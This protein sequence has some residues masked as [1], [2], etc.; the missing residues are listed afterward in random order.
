MSDLPFLFEAEPI[1]TVQHFLGL[2]WPGPWRMVSLLG[3]HG[4]IALAV[5][6]A[7]WL[8]GR[9]A[10]YPLLAIVIVE[11][12]LKIALN[13]VFGVS[14]PTAEGIVMYEQVEVPAFPSGHIATATA[15]WGW[16]ALRRLVS[17]WF[18]VPLIILVAISRLY[19]GVH[20]VGDVLG[21]ILLG[22][23]VFLLIDRFWARLRS[24]LERPPFSF[25]VGIAFL[26]VVGVMVG[27][28]LFFA[29]KGHLWRGGGLIAGFALGL[30]LEYRLLDYRPT[31]RPEQPTLGLLLMGTGGVAVLQ[32][33]DLT[34][35]QVSHL[36]GF[37]FMALAALWAVFVAPALFVKIGWSQ[38]RQAPSLRQGD[39]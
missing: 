4:G 11:A 3:S 5:G 33:L 37:G 13:S 20:F 32:F 6:I 26:S 36:L 15:I 9:R 19:L 17:W 1:I 25:Y 31:D 16:L 2:G 28:L 35:G 39:P 7:F 24:W 12:V 27:G 22:V 34:I 30:P 38:P 8:G 21:G 18:A 14:R 10:G 23:L 29:D